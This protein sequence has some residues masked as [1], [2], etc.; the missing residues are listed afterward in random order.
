M[1]RRTALRNSTLLFG[2]TLSSG[3][4]LSLLS[5]CTVPDNTQLWQPDFFSTKEGQLLTKIA[6]L[7]IPESEVAG[8]VGVGVP[9]LIDQLAKEYML[10]A[11]QE[12]LQTG[13]SAFADKFQ[14]Q[15]GQSFL[16]ADAPQQLA[17][18]QAA[19]QIAVNSQTPTFLG[20]LKQ[21]IYEGYFKSEV[22]AT[23]VLKFN[24]VPGG[25]QGCV[26]FA[27]VNGTWL[28]LDAFV[29]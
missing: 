29:L 17:F 19:E 13:F 27:E 15:N 21:L 20:T 2:F 9:Q 18:L 14:Q 4:V 7:M 23:E 28:S 16:E 11:E 1:N 22:G 3:T 12:L 5:G 8:A 25:F 6:E 26:P 24:P 10:P